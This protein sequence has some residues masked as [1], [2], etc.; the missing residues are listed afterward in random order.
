MNANS[1]TA[2]VR[3]NTRPGDGPNVRESAVDDCEA[4][5]DTR[6]DKYSPKERLNVRE[7]AIGER[8]ATGVTR[9][10]KYS[11][12]RRGKCPRECRQ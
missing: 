9:M 1:P 11:P 3:T 6:T 2:P 4:N 7:S 5:D 12:R 8:N 10:D